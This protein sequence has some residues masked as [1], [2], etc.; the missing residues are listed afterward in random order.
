MSWFKHYEEA[1]N[2]AIFYGGSSNFLESTG[3]GVSLL[4]DWRNTTHSFGYINSYTDNLNCLTK[5]EKEKRTYGAG[6]RVNGTTQVVENPG[7]I[8]FKY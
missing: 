8:L 4:Y 3:E 7:Q 2:D 6:F 1:N 5:E